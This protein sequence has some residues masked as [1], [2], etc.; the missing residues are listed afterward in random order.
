[1]MIMV[2]IVDQVGISSCGSR[3]NE[4]K[5]SDELRSADAEYFSF[6]NCLLN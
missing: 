5:L 1:M 4:A 2:T 6:H 3:A